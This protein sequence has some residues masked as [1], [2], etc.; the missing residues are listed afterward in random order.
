MDLAG[1][2]AITVEELPNQT[3]VLVNGETC[4]TP[5]ETIEAIKTLAAGPGDQSTKGILRTSFRCFVSLYAAASG[6]RVEDGVMNVA[7][8]LVMMAM[9]HRTRRSI[10]PSRN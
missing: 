4:Q 1:H 3:R 5:E 8:V 7:D 2:N 6:Q 10:S 9:A